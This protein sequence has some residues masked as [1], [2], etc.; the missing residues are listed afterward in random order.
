MKRLLMAI[1]LA[2]WLGGV[3]F[4]DNFGTDWIDRITHEVQK[5]GGPL[6]NRPVDF[7]VYGGVYGYYTDN[8][9][10]GNNH[11]ADGDWAALGFARGRVDYSD[12]KLELAAELLVNYAYYLETHEAREDEERFFGKARY[13]DGVLDLQIVEIARRE[14]D[15]LD[16]V[17]ADR[18]RRIVTD[19]LPRA[20][21]KIAELVTIE[22]FG[23]IETV[24]FE[25]SKFDARENENY[26][27]GLGVYAD[28]SDKIAVGAQAGYLRI[29]YRQGNITPSA[30]GWF[31]HASVRG[32]VT[33]RFLVEVALG[34]TRIHAFH[35][36]AGDDERQSNA[37]FD[38]EVHLRYELTETL[39]IFGDYTRRFGFAGFGSSYQAVDRGLLIV[40]WQA[41]EKLKLRARAQ[42]DRVVP[43]EAFVRTYWAASLGATYQVTANFAVDAGVTYRGGDTQGIANDT[44]DNWI[45]YLGVIV[46][47]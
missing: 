13:A 41:I 8:L 12:S 44:Y 37:T 27:A 30:D 19:T 24:H 23:Q 2:M 38:A 25:G 40:E 46:G 33:S 42:Y 34:W 32:E 10:L 1:G 29:H 9:F 26:R 39:T 14:S 43:S 16:G 6:S 3:A 31:A 17:F 35:K 28:L 5:E 22:A 20:G 15:A 36:E 45:G 4:A 18:A 21:V 11:D 7:H 47:F